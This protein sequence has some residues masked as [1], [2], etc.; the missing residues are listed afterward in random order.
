[1]HYLIFPSK[2]AT[3]YSEYPNKNTGLDQI[4]EINKIVE[5]GTD[6]N[7][8]SRALIQFDI[9]EY[10]TYINE[11]DL[12]GSNAPKFYLNIFTANSNQLTLDNNIEVY[13]ISSSWE[14]GVGVIDS[15]TVKGV[16]WNY[17]TELY[18]WDNTGSDYINSVSSSQNYGY[19]SYD[20]R[21][22]VTD[23]INYW[24]DNDNNNGF[25]IK[26]SLSQENDEYTY[27]SSSFYSMDTHTLY[28]P[29]LEMVWDD[30]T[31]IP[32]GSAVDGDIILSMINLK[33]Q[34]LQNST[35]KLNIRV[36]ESHVRKTFFEEYTFNSVNYV[37]GS[38]TFYY[39]IQDAYNGRIMIPFSEYSKV[40]LDSNGHYIKLKLSGFMPERYYKIVY[41]INS[42]DADYYI[43]NNY[44]FKV[45]K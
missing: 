15:N 35:I 9:S 12:T 40:S 10:E 45:V 37:S 5:E 38:D 39:Q 8:V 2:D 28:V 3:I 31:Y 44:T 27:G 23:I 18:E 33:K 20:L 34:Y 11:N 26:R 7:N 42:D 16:S 24:M 41:K 13:P 30:Q 19:T 29:Y 22:D 1:M 25:L 6:I 43:D 36:K 17:R 4:L 21:F 32:T 14:M